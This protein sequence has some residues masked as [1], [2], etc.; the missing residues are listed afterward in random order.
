MY[1][2]VIIYHDLHLT[3]LQHLGRRKNIE[4]VLGPN[5]LLWCWPTVTPGNGLKYQL[6]NGDGEWLELSSR[7]KGPSSP[8]GWA[9]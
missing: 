5:P 9:A 6:A 7:K 2:Q 1:V 3:L 4:S 8:H